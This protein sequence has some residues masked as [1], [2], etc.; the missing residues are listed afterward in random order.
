M[1]VGLMA[2]APRLARTLGRYPAA[3]DSMLD[4]RFQTQLGVNT[5]LFEQM[6]QEAAAAPDF[7]EAMNAVRRLH[8]DQMFRIGVQILSGRIDAQEA[9]RAHTALA[10]GV[11]QAL[12]P[13]AIAE[14]R[15]L[16]GDIEGA[17]AVIALGKAGSGEMTAG[18]DLDLMTVYAAPPDVT[19]TIKDWAAGTWFGRFT[20]RLVAALSS[21]TAEGGMYEVDMRLRPGGSK[22]LVS[23]SLSGLEDYYASEADTWEF[24][25]RDPRPRGL[26]QR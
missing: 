24:M 23:V 15:R 8:R 10:D 12:A 22:G 25:A 11:I 2:L 21:H 3:L 1:L 17:V 26:G 6:S 7:E 16:G 5:G 19:S 14:T 18:S 20:Q 13:A 9:G 4:A